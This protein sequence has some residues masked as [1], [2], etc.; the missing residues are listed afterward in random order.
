MPSV[1]MTDTKY[2]FIMRRQ[3]LIC[4]IFGMLL[5][6]AC[7][8]EPP[9]NRAHLE[10][11]PQKQ[12]Q[13]PAKPVDT[14]KST[15]LV[16]NQATQHLLNAETLLQSGDNQ[17]AQKEL[18]IINYANMPIEQRSKFNLL[19]AQIALSMG[20]AERAYSKLENIRPKLLTD[21]DKLNYYQ[22]L[23]F[24]HTLMGNVLPAVNA[25]IR[26]GNLL[27]DPEKQRLNIITVLDMLGGLPMETLNAPPS[28]YDELSGWMSLAKIL[29]ERKQSGLDVSAQIQQWRQTYPG[30]PANAEFLQAYLS[31]PQTEAASNIPVTPGANI[32]VFLPASGALAQAGKAIRDGLQVA[33]RVAAS[34]S[35]QLP[36]KYY[37]SSQGDIAILYQQ[38]VADGAKQVI[39]PLVKEQIQALA[40][41]SD[42]NV[43][44]L[45]LNHVENLRKT[46][47][48]QFGLSPIDEAEQLALKARREGH[49]S[50]VLLMP[51]NALGQRVGTYLSSA[52][53]RN[54]GSVAGMQSYDPKLHDIGNVLKELLATTG[55]ATA[56]K[57][58]PAV[59]V[60]A[61]PEQGRELAV[62]I[63]S[64]QNQDLAVY[65]MPNIYRGHQSPVQDA[66][67]G[68]I[69]FCDMPWLF[70]ETYGGILSQSAL[71][72]T[73]QNL[74]ESQIR[75]LALG[76]DAYNL[77]GQFG[78]LSTT[79]YAG[80][81]GHLSLNDENRVTRKLV[82]AQFK[83][84]VPVASGYVD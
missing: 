28:M 75:L 61:N 43:P 12:A 77:I 80:A 42:L 47:L 57:A 22:S 18:D 68:K 71:Q 4:W 74:G 60:S 39:G 48:Y 34:T 69:N 6:P 13:K 53:Q 55:D 20:E 16:E 65:A 17:A 5:L 7:A 73:W 63:K 9:K 14:V 35:P 44:V 50:A 11:R 79:S 82:C 81:T 56:Q 31:K 25:R 23:A 40:E 1:A 51:N 83:A 15:A 58:S 66:E 59:L 33:H 30:H 10:V 19:D 3:R 2:A 84:G 37:D 54:G 26:L 41:I 27:T 46:N 64:L 24:A 29:K 72:G 62:Y 70:A 36:L 32:A 38:A 52:W 49:Q 67:L 45:A 78:Q 21:A 8:Q 76:I